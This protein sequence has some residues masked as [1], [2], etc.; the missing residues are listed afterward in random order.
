MVQDPRSLPATMML[1]L[2]LSATPVEARFRSQAQPKAGMGSGHPAV[3]V[4][5]WGWFIPPAG[6]NP[7]K[8]KQNSIGYMGCTMNN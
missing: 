3:L 7:R 8:K 2:V 4:S 1:E 6:G 5:H